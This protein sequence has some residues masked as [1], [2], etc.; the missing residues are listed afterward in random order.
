MSVDH[1]VL[2]VAALI[3]AIAVIVWAMLLSRDR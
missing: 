3:L 2:I 1:I